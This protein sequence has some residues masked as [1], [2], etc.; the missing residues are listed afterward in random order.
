MAAILTHRQVCP[1][2]IQPQGEVIYRF[3]NRSGVVVKDSVVST[4]DHPRIV[5]GQ[6]KDD[7]FL[8]IAERATATSARV[9]TYG[10]REVGGR[11]DYVWG[12]VAAALIAAEVIRRRR[13]RSV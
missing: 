11:R 1:Q 9:L 3:K 7:S 13:G 2:V 5:G 12:V 6:L 8:R 4:R 10:E